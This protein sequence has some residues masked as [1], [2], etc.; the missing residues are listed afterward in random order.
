MS[1]QS[2]LR[3]PAP[4]ALLITLLLF[5]ASP[6]VAQ[7]GEVWVRIHHPAN[8]PALQ[9]L[10][11]EAE[12]ED[13][14]H[15]QWGRVSR[16]SIEKLQQ[17]G[18]SV[19]VS[20]SPFDLTLGGETF[21]PLRFASQRN[22]VMGD[23]DGQF[24]LVQFNGPIRARWLSDL[25]ASGVQVAQPLYPFSY[26]V[27]A[28]SAQIGSLRSLEA[29]RT[30]LP[31]QPEWKVQPHLREFDGEIRPTMALASAHVDERELQTDLER[32]GIVHSI[33]PLNRHFRVVHLDV[34]GS[35]YDRL[36]D[37]GAVYTVQYIQQDAGPRGEMSNQSIVGGIDGGSIQTG[38]LD[39][40]NDTGL[41][42]QGIAVGIVD[43]G[44]Q[45]SHPDLTDNMIPCT[46]TEGSCTGSS[47]SH[48]THVAGAVG[49]TGQS[50]VTD[51]GG[52]L[53]GQGV[54]PGASLINQA[55]GPFLGAGPGGMV[56]EGM[57]SIYKDSA[58]SG[59]LLTNNSWGP[60][61]SPQG[62]DIPTMEI[63]FISRDALPDTPGHQP[64]LAV[65]SIMNGG[66]DG[67]GACAPSSLGSPD[68]AKNLFGVGSTGLQ[69]GSG[70][71]VPIADVFSVS[72]NSAHGPACDGRRVPDIVA[73]G[74]STDSTDT[75]SS[76]GLKCG[77]S[78]ASPVVSGAIALWAEGYVA[79]TGNDPS[80]A[81]MKAVFIAAARDLEG[82][83]NADGG[84]LGHRPDR[85]QGYGRLDLDAVM[86]PAG[87]E[88]YLMDQ[89]QVFTES[90][91]DWGLA[92]VA[93]DPAEP[94]QV[95]LT[96][97][98][99]PG[100]GLGGTTPAWVN[101]LDLQVSALDGN[102]YLG[103]VVGGDGWSA[104]GGSPDGMNNTEAVWLQP[105][106]HQGGFDLTVLATDIAGDALNPHDPGDPSQ[107]FAIACYNCLIGDP[108]FSLSL[109]PTTIEACIPE[110]GSDDFDVD[111]SVNAIGAYSGTVSLSTSGEPAG[112]GSAVD[113][114][115]VVVPG[116]STWTL[117]VADT[118]VAGAHPLLIEGDDGSDI[119]DAGLSLVLDEYLDSAAALLAP[120]DGASDLALRPTFSWDELGGISEYRIQVATDSGFAGIV[121][122]E[123]VA[124]DTSFVPAADL[125]LGT[126]YF[127]RV[128]GVNLCG[129]GDWSEVFSFTTRLEP[130]ADLSATEFSFSVPAGLIAD[131]TL[132]IGNTGTG[133]LTF[134]ISTDE[135][136]AA[137]RGLGY[138][139]ARDEVLD[140][141]DFS[142]TGAAGG[143]PVVEFDIPGGVATQGTAV[144]FTFEG[145]VAGISSTGD[146]AS[147]MRMV[148]TG[149]DGDSFDVGGFTN[150]AN[151]WEFQG[152]GSASDGTYAST[153]VPAF[154]AEG[155]G[156]TGDWSL[157]FRHG[158]ES[159]SAGTMDWSEVTV[160]L[161]KTAPPYC[162]EEQVAADW[163]TVSPDSGSVAAGESEPVTITV[164]ASGLAEGD[165][166]AWVCVATNDPNAPMIPVAVNL[167]VTEAVEPQIFE[168]RFEAASP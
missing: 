149:P 141:P 111:V 26:F 154:G 117:S 106:Q 121:I 5:T 49:G 84:A 72:S 157:D 52:F 28:T 95:V 65:W 39:W 75:G 118:A 142:V 8:A 156:D 89:E 122:D 164:D 29:V 162:G 12:L 67:G 22:L 146:W 76:Y 131:D 43:G 140:V 100:H 44:V 160:T 19:T 53:R 68:E 115:S 50:G 24:H 9:S 59:A 17:R 7:D 126:E 63:D 91:Q 107:D 98:D 64:V 133:N 159:D 20:D 13:Y 88:V 34:A 165:Y 152:S 85:F 42:G 92:L 147:D 153:H 27:W 102:T 86:N 3:G 48:G 81:L 138:D 4:T 82:G 168:D 109:N 150:P 96:W 113:P 55:Y 129:G 66:G 139:P 116:S 40:L 137:L 143:G 132:Q 101:D 57:L 112:V 125:D 6:T 78:M 135:P 83:T 11:I 77:T 120:A 14:G 46:G 124:D 155:T 151:D 45:E 94:M 103:N 31:V 99:A 30:T 15:F 36:A 148:I 1:I 38:Y 166:S 23:P 10:A 114:D 33:T 2:I 110:A 130:A 69:T 161:H 128:Q 119:H 127:W 58:D 163:I 144:G 61:G 105:S 70:A 54:A 79:A 41:D 62:Y 60:T 104:P 108:T 97:T 80:P 37:L 90:G 158:W 32:V 16:D 145:T 134:E 51:S 73:P 21:D 93:A 71:Q 74:C 18:L 56:P 35:D 167:T 87:G 123:T 47:S 136:E 25:R